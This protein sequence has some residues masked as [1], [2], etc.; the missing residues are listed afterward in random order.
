MAK[1]P[2]VS[3]GAF[4]V[5]LS[6]PLQRT[7]HREGPPKRVFLVVVVVMVAIDGFMGGSIRQVPGLVKGP[8]C[9]FRSRRVVARLCP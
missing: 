9:D 1:A 4:L 7:S 5:G 8:L 3:G 2:S 6:S